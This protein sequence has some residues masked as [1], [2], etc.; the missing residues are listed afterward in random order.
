MNKLSGE[1]G[2]DKAK[3]R[4]EV[5]P[6]VRRVVEAAGVEVGEGERG[7]TMMGWWGVEMARFLG[8]ARG[9]PEGVSS[10]N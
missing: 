8:F 7:E 9:L 3:K 1:G 4:P 5:K 2:G 10:D 6:W